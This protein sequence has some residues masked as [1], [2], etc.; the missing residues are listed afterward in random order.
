M[1][2]R[3]CGFGYFRFEK[4]GKISFGASALVSL[5]QVMI[6]TNILGFS[7]NEFYEHSDRQYVMNKF[8]PFYIVIILII[9]FVNDY[10]YKN[11]YNAFKEKWENQSKT[12]K[13]IYGFI[14]LL[15]LIVPLVSVPIMLGLFD[16]R[17]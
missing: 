7:I 10:R 12:E 4:K 13:S 1:Y 2:Y 11:K 9:A 8:R 3:L 16:F 15:L 14:I 5:S 17:K 6:L